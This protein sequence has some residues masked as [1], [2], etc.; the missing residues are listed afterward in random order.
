[1]VLHN[2]TACLFLLSSYLILGLILRVSFTNVNSEDEGYCCSTLP[3][4]HTGTYQLEEV[5]NGEY[6]Y[7]Y[8]QNPRLAHSW[9]KLKDI[10][11]FIRPTQDYALW[12][13]MLPNKKW[14]SDLDNHTHT[15]GHQKAL[16][17]AKS[18]GHM[19]SSIVLCMEEWWPTAGDLGYSYR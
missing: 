2:R 12:T 6:A 17:F 15:T 13:I 3:D 19:E 8:V 18:K 1:M 14:A 16:S 7:N 10:Q 4:L 11:W 5:I 9:Q